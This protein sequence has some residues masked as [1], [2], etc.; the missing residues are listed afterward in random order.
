MQTVLDSNNQLT[1]SPDL[2]VDPD[3]KEIMAL[4]S[5]PTIFKLI[6]GATVHDAENHFIF[7]AEVYVPQPLELAVA[8]MLLLLT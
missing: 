8:I 4:R 7:V 1:F 6:N 2:I 5:L 3:T